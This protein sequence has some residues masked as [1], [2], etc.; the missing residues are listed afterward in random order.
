MASNSSRCV[1]KELP[2]PAESKRA[3]PGKGKNTDTFLSDK[4][5]SEEDIPKKDGTKDTAVPI[6]GANVKNLKSK[7]ESEVPRAFISKDKKLL[8]SPNDYEDADGLDEGTTLTE[9]NKVVCVQNSNDK[10]RNYRKTIVRDMVNEE[11]HTSIRNDNNEED[12]IKVQG[13]TGKR[14]DVNSES[15]RA[16]VISKTRA[17]K[18]DETVILF[19][20]CFAKEKG[21]CSTS[22]ILLIKLIFRWYSRVFIN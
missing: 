8:R 2:D 18:T 9:S 14:K 6:Y 13:K 21:Y 7:F 12:W 19:G 4:Q 20:N 22:G 11:E 17:H 1:A 16:N 5:T 3:A 15:Q 10:D